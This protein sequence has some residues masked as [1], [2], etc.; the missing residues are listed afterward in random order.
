M[1]SAIALN[2][3]DEAIKEL[4]RPIKFVQ[5]EHR[6]RNEIVAKYVIKVEGSNLIMLCCLSF[7]CAKFIFNESKFKLQES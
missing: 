2:L 6:E 5:S 4:K 7:V 3:T 1:L